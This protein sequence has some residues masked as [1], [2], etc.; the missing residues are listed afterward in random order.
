MNYSADTVK[1]LEVEIVLSALTGVFDAV[2]SEVFCVQSDDVVLTVCYA[3]WADVHCHH[4]GRKSVGAGYPDVVDHA[5]QRI[6]SHG[7]R[8]RPYTTIPG[9]VVEGH[10]DRCCR[11]EVGRWTKLDLELS[12]VA[13][14]SRFVGDPRVVDFELIRKCIEVID[15]GVEIVGIPL[16]N[17]R[18]VR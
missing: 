14:P 13:S 16:V 4:H 11:E 17:N 2:I 1:E 10:L 9:V 15:G 6:R 12:D 3:S 7:V 18:R 5:D 8:G